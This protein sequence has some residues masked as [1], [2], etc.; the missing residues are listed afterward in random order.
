[1]TELKRIIDLYENF[2]IADLEDDLADIDNRIENLPSYDPEHKLR[3]V[4]YE[5]VDEL[6]YNN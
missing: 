3:K 1:M 4:I 5:I 6:K 2:M